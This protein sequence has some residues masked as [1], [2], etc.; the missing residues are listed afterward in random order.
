MEGCGDVHGAGEADRWGGV[1]A[2]RLAMGQRHQPRALA[3]HQPDEIRAQRQG[4]G[5]G[6]RVG[7]VALDQLQLQLADGLAGGGVCGGF[8]AGG[9]WCGGGDLAVI[10]HDVDEGGAVADAA[11]DARDMG[12]AARVDIGAVEEIGQCR[13]GDV[14]PEG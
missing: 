4:G 11:A 13:A 9:V 3:R 8:V 14:G 6:Q 10:G 2:R 7:E 5:Q 12:G 1:G